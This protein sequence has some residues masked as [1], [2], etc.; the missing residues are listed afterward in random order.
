VELSV[1]DLGG[2]RITSLAEAYYGVGHHE[3]VWRARSADGRRL[4]SG[5]YFVRLRVGKTQRWQR[6]LLLK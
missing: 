6:I 3:V 1:Y 2:Q 5:V 4:A